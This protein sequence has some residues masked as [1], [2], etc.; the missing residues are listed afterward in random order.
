[1]GAAGRVEWEADRRGRGGDR[2][3][4]PS[5]G[6]PDRTGRGHGLMSMIG[7][8]APPLV[9]GGIGH[10]VTRVDGTPK[11]QGAFEYASDL[12]AEGMLFGQTVRSPKAH[13]RIVSIDASEALAALGVCAVMTMEDVTGKRTFGLEFSDQPVLADGVV[14]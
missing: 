2:H 4:G 8:V 11:V 3:Q 7:R 14:R 5:R 13:A 9:R 10:S 6:A 1:R 12:H